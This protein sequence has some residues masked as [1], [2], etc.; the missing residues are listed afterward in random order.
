[1]LYSVG[2]TKRKAR[3][4][5]VSMRKLKHHVS[6]A[7]VYEF[8]DVVCSCDS[9][10]MLELEYNTELF[11]ATNKL[12][13]RAARSLESAKSM[14]SLLGHRYDLKEDYEL[15][16]FFCQS[17]QDILALNSIKN[18]RKRCQTAVCWLDE[19]WM[20]DVNKWQ[21]QLKLL[22]NFDH[23]FMNFASSIEKASRIIQK[24]CH[25][26]PYAVDALKFAYPHALNRGV[27][28]LNI[29]RR[30]GITHDALNDLANQGEILY[31]YDTL[32]HLYMN[33]IRH[34]RD[35]YANLLKRSQFLIVNKAK[36][37]LIGKTNPQ[38]EV[39]PRFFEG[40]AAGAVMLGAAPQ[41][42]VFT[43]N[44]DWADAV[45]EIPF[46]SPD[47]GEIL[48]GL[49]AQ[50]E[51][52]KLIRRNGV[53]NSLLRH[54]WVYRWEHMLNQVGM[55]AE[56]QLLERKA[57][58]QSLSETVDTWFMPEYTATMAKAA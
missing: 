28:V 11:K 34:H 27:D 53:V 36:F 10:D 16:F 9:V 6:R 43:Q 49:K 20:N 24:P 45:I 56:P 3:V 39:G 13:N 25:P 42:E 23:V 58:L 7:A 1:M 31:I 55:K 38:D 4:L 52:L 29:G 33:N 5:A 30:S 17:P 35:L 21:N 12:F 40:A 54:D 37:D 50:P 46:N 26:I 2:S 19:V 14:N 15:F 41:C 8:E 57:H 47:I 44:F 51:R 18:W 22:R 48:N 32:K